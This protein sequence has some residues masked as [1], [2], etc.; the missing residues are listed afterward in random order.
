M[1]N[2]VNLFTMF[3]QDIPA[4]TTDYMMM[5]YAVIFGTMLIYLAS[6]VVRWRN[7]K[8]DQEV[9]EELENKN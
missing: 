1:V 9:L 7:M 3:L 2:L 8:K 4:E 6:L 5:G